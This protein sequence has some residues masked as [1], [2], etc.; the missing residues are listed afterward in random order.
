MRQKLLYKKLIHQWVST[1]CN[2]SHAVQNLDKYENY[3][4]YWHLYK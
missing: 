1:T 3:Y 4:K 2:A